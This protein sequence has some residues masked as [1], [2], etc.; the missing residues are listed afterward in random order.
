MK[1]QRV[2]YLPIL[3]VGEGAEAERLGALGVGV[4][5]LVRLGRE[6]VQVQLDLM[7][8]ARGRLFVTSAM[9]ATTAAMNR[10]DVQADVDR[11][12]RVRRG[13]RVVVLVEVAPRPDVGRGRV[14][15]PVGPGC[16]I[17]PRPLA[18]PLVIS[19]VM[20]DRSLLA[21]CRIAVDRVEVDVVRPRRCRRRRGRG[22][23][24]PRGRVAVYLGWILWGS[25]LV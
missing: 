6:Q 20:A 2:F 18:V 14:V 21:H 22:W 8:V 12:G 16:V 19:V 17:D 3:V 4:Q 25:R 24:R 7:T 10:I 9:M 13:P 11:Q 15:R 23:R 5:A 1:S